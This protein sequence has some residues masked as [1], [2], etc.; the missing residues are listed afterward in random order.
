MNNA[1]LSELEMLNESQWQQAVEELLPAIH[2]VDRNAVQIWFRFYPLDLVRYLESA[3]NIEDAMKGIV[4]S[5]DFG[6]LDK[7][8][9]SHRFLFGHRFWPQVKAAVEA[10]AASCEPFAGLPAEISSIAKTAAVSA[11]TSET[12]TTAIAAV[13]VMTLVQAGLDDLKKAPGIAA[14]PEGVMTGPPDQIVMERAKDDSQGLF[15]FLKTVDKKFSVHFKAFGS[16]GTF[17]I[18]NEE[19]ITSASQ[20]D[21]DRDWQALDSRCWEG[22]VPIECT[23]ASCGTCWIGVLGGQE[24]LSD[25]STRERRQMKLFGHDQPDSAKPFIRLACQAEASGNVTIVIPP[26]NAVFGKRVRKNIEDLE[27]EPVTSSAAKLRETIKNATA[28]E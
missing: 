15:G 8:D 16:E 10:R 5:G 25:V 12:L 17:P 26:W 21:R 7:I 23:S 6:L 13:G 3:E 18:I 2:E 14:K 28:G 11:K 19:E 20:K 9:T 1:F 27:L 24:K 4:M 22:P